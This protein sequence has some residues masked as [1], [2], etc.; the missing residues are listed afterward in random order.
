MT[1]GILWEATRDLHH[2]CEQHQVGAALATGSPPVAWYADW[3][4]ALRQLHEV[5]D[6]NLPESLGRVERL[7]LDLMAV[8]VASNLS[9]AAHAYSKTL[10]TE[11]A[12][13]GAAYVLTGAHLMG[14]EVMRRRLAGFPTEHL[15]WEDRKI[16]LGWL[17]PVRERVELS[18]SARACF[19]A[20]LAIMTEIQER[21]YDVK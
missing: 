21:K 10:T 12:L 13:D 2:A 19:G 7:T 18:E 4:M 11:V 9:P 3:L 16:G 6:K 20:L 5:V 1:P 17:K 8:G 15:E 14:G